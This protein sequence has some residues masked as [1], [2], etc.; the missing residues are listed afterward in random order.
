[1]SNVLP[2][3]VTKFDFTRHLARADVI[4]GA[5]G[6]VVLIK[7]SKSFKIEEML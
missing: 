5:T 1:M 6:A 7:W 2:H 4:F 3:A